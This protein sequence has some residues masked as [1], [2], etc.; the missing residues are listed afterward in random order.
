MLGLCALGA[1][2]E[3]AL[4]SDD[5]LVAGSRPS[6]LSVLVKAVQDGIVVGSGRFTPACRWLVVAALGLAAC[7]ADSTTSIAPSSSMASPSTTTPSTTL[8][9]EAPTNS[10]T[11]T[12]PPPTSTS[13]T[14][15]EPFPPLPN[16][17]PLAFSLPPLFGAV[18][19]EMRVVVTADLAI[20]ELIVIDDAGVVVA[21][22][23]PAPERFWI[24]TI[25]GAAVV[26]DAMR[27]TAHARL[28]DGTERDSAEVNV[29]IVT[30][31]ASTLSLD[32]VDVVETV[33][34]DRPWSDAPG[35]LAYIPPE[36]EGDYITPVAIA[37]I[38]D[39][40]VAVLD[41]A[42]SRVTCFDLSGAA[43][44]HV[45]LPVPAIGDLISVGDGTLLVT[46]FGN[47]AGAQEA[48]V[49]RVDPRQERVETVYHEYPL[50]VEGFPGVA[51]NL[52]FSWDAAARTAWVGRPGPAPADGPPDA[53]LLPLVDALHLDDPVTRGPTIQRSAF[54]QSWTP[55]AQWLI[56]G[57]AQLVLAGDPRWDIEE[58]AVTD[59]GLV[60]MLLY[61]LRTDDDGTSTVESAIGRWRPGDAA[62]EIA[63]IERGMGVGGTRFLAPLGD[64]SAAVLDV[65]IGSRIRVFTLP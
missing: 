13:T 31:N 36:D 41:P 18:G 52:R 39:H 2:M 27:L 7:E 60:W 34:Y 45:P 49:L 65:N 42:A 35:E 5:T 17:E 53:S 19:V 51:I 54:S 38:S 4:S 28:R 50:R 48:T 8:A 55:G 63:S 47:R 58:T 12:S 3:L 20:D 23:M 61:Q 25:P 33:V 37:A 10:T 46:H 16:G 22:L 15:I 40:E 9:G 29:P 26:G 30:Q 59:T 11:P 62:I 24:G 6:T 1:A 44:C 57:P 56:D 43:T 32:S 21:T 14:V 64:T